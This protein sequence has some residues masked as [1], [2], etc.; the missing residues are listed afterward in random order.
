MMGAMML[1]SM[2]SILFI[3]ETHNKALLETVNEEELSVS[4]E[5]TG[6]IHKQSVGAAG[7]KA[8][9][10]NGE[11]SGSLDVDSMSGVVGRDQSV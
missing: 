5:Q 10:R 1:A 4:T 6:N 9:M 7:D 8:G 2:V 11:H 3:P